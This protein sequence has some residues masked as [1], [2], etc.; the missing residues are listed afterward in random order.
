MGIRI[1]NIE[2][3]NFK[4]YKNQLFDFEDNGLVVLDGPN[5]FGKTSLYDALELLFTGKIRRYEKA[6][7]ILNDKREKRNE[8]PFYH[9]D[10]D[11]SPMVIKAQI[12]FNGVEHIIARKNLN[13]EETKIDFSLFKLHKLNHFDEAIDESNLV[14]EN[15]LKTILGENYQNDFQFVNYVEQE[16][17]FYYLKSSEKEKKEGISYLFNTSNF[18]YEIERINTVHNKIA[19]LLNG[20]IGLNKRI[21]KSEETIAIL[22]E[23]FKP[24]EGVNYEKLFKNKDFIWDK[25]EIDFNSISYNEIFGNEEGTVFKLEKFIKDKN[26]FLAEIKNSKINEIINN[27]NLVESLI[28]YDNFRDSEEEILVQKNIVNA[29]NEFKIKFES[30]QIDEILIESYDLPELVLSKFQGNEIV[31]TYVSKLR[32]LKVYLSNSNQSSKIIANLITTKN[33]LEIH[34]TE[35]H[36]KIKKD[37]VCPFCGNDWITSIDLI[38]NIEK[39]KNDFEQLNIDIDQ[40][41]KENV[42]SFIQF[43][44]DSLLE[45]VQRILSDFLYK[46][47]YFKDDFFDIASKRKLTLLK[48]D[49][50]DFGVEYTKFL[51]NDVKFEYEEKIEFFIEALKFKL[52]E[53]NAAVIESFYKE[54]YSHYFDSKIDALEGVSLEMIENKKKYI[55]WSYSLF[56]SGLLKSK[57]EELSLLKEKREKLSIPFENIKSVLSVMNGSLSWYNSQLIKDIEVLFHIYSGRIVQD[58]QGG[59][60]LFIINRGD[61]V[62][63]VTTPDKTYDAVFSMSTGQLSALVLSFT[64][65]LNKKYSISK[66]LLIDDPVQSMD[67][68]NTAGFVEVLRNDFS[69]RQI[70]FSTHE[71]SMSTYLRYKFKKFDIDSTRIDLSDLKQNN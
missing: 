37:G 48:L 1:K 54:Y 39:Q 7:A 65:A 15:Y 50:I 25:E 11:G 20:E 24:V 46:P 58:F 21:G 53:Y 13:I 12:Q 64:L 14:S 9:S 51:S 31:D 60:G 28:K 63:F 44:K 26:N 22:E 19:N 42:E 27:E 47:E 33:K 38:Q 30:F 40:T 32:I 71:N 62:K 59:L 49:L 3:Q 36:D 41:L 4:I 70:V 6:T 43:T 10:G 35:Y 66:L 29:F 45:E 67:D 5:G 52:E 57:K 69:D 8:N 55:E 16:E 68:I 23:S 18:D 17:T 61:K 34:L 2:I 56:Q